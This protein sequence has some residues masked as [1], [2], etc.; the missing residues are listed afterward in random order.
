MWLKKKGMECVKSYEDKT[1]GR[2]ADV[3][4]KIWRRL[5]DVFEFVNES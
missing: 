3:G 4:K 1:D 5:V 2:K